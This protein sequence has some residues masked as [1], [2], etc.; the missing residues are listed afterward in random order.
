MT[1][2]VE[3]TP[4]EQGEEKLA[5]MLKKHPELKKYAKFMVYDNGEIVYKVI[6]EPSKFDIAFDDYFFLKNHPED[7]NAKFI[8]DFYEYVYNLVNKW[9][10]ENEGYTIDCWKDHYT[11]RKSDEVEKIHYESMSEDEKKVY[12][13]RNLQEKINSKREERNNLLI[14]VVD[15][16][17][18]NPLRWEELTEAEQSKYRAYRLYLLDIPQQEEFPDIEIK[19][20]EEFLK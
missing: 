3:K 7:E 9:C 14:T 8:D 5:K 18:T 4:K 10:S 6:V 15:P 11:V 19:S 20:F 1:D 16:V 2:E 12:D 17:V 13:E